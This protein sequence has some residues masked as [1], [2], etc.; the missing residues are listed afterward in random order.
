LFALAVFWFAGLLDPLRPLPAILAATSAF[1]A[2]VTCGIG[3]ASVF[4]LGRVI[5]RLGRQFNVSLTT[6]PFGVLSTG[7]TLAKCYAAISLVW[8]AY[9]LSASKGLS[10]QY[11]ALALLSL[12]AI[13]FLVGSFILCQ[14]PL[15]ERMVAA[16]RELVREAE[17][18]L[19]SATVLS[20][21]ALDEP[22]MARTRYLREV[23]EDRLRLPEWPFGWP[24]LAQVS[25]YAMGAHL[26][27]LIEGAKFLIKQ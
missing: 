4:Y 14:C 8:L 19:R 25:L 21:T 13:A 17:L 22:S 23:Y 2:S 9:T 15:H 1:V 18:A 6:S 5:W 3:L 7:R 12:P 11:V 20:A 24:G 16:K 27:A 26:P 10:G